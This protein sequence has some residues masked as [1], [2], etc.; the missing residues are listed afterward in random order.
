MRRPT[1]RVFV[2]VSM[3]V[4]AILACQP[5]TA[6]TSEVS[7]PVSTDSPVIS[8]TSTPAL[9]SVTGIITDQLTGK[10]LSN[11]LVTAYISGLTSTTNTDGSYYIGDLPAGKEFI[12]VGEASHE[13]AFQSVNI[14]AGNTSTANFAIGPTYWVLNKHVLEGRV[15]LNSSPVA[16]A[17]VWICSQN[18]SD[19]TDNNGQYH[20]EF[21]TGASSNSFLILVE[22]GDARGGTEVNLSAEQITT[23]PDI[24]LSSQ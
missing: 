24:I 6:P 20:I 9:G 12:T 14:S 8:P 5:D 2:A 3:L 1:I 21:N 7:L 15:L 4:L 10:I 23:A 16:G 13:E 22:L 19:T 18:G 17:R 11:V